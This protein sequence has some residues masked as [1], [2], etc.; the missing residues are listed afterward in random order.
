M[1]ANVRR[2]NISALFG[3]C[4]RLGRR[5]GAVA[6][7]LAL[8]AGMVP[9]VGLLP[10]AAAA[11]EDE[12]F[13]RFNAWDAAGKGTVSL[14]E[15]VSGN[16]ALLTMNGGGEAT[17]TST[18][19]AVTAGQKYRAGVSVKSD[20]AASAAALRVQ[21]FSDADGKK[22]VGE[23]TE[24]AASAPGAAFA[25][26]AGDVTVPEGARYAKLAIAFGNDKSA[27]GETYAADN[28]FLYP[29][30]R[31]API[32]DFN[33]AGLTPGQ[34]YRYPDGAN[35]AWIN[36][37]QYYVETVE[38][39]YNGAGALHYVNTD[40]IHDMHLVLIA[41]QD[42]PAGEYKVSMWVKGSVT[43]KGQDLRF[44]DA[45]NTDNTDYIITNDTNTFADWTECSYTYTSNGSRDFFLKFSRYNAVSD[46]YISHI[47]VTNT[48]TGEDVLDG[49]G[50]F[51]AAENAALVTAVNFV[52]NGDFED[53]IYTYLPLS[54]FNGSFTEAKM[55]EQPLG[56][57]VNDNADNAVSLEAAT[58]GGHG[59]VLKATRHV[60]SENWVSVGTNPIAVEG[61]T[62]Y[63]FSIDMKGTGTRRHYLLVG[64]T[65][66]RA[67]NPTYIANDLGAGMLTGAQEADLPNDWAT[68]S[69]AFTV[70]ANAVQLQIR[71]VFWG[72]VGDTMLLDNASLCPYTQAATFPDSWKYGG[73]IMPE[74]DDNAFVRLAEEGC[75]N[76]NV[77]SLHVRRSYEVYHNGG[78]DL[79]FGYLLTN[80]PAGKNYVLK[81]MVKGN[82]N[83]AGDPPNME[84]AWG[85]G[86]WTAT[87]DAVYRF[88]N[89]EYTD[90]TEV[91]FEFTSV[92][93]DWAPILFNVGGYVGTDFYIDNVRLYAAN[94]LNTNLIP[95]G[96]FFTWSEADTSRNLIPNGGFEGLRVLSVPGWSFS[97]DI[98]YAA[99]SK[100]VTFG[101]NAS[102]TS[103]RYNVEGGAIYRVKVD[104]NGG[105]LQLSFDK[106]AAYT[107]TDANG[108]FIVP[109]GAKYM[110]ASYVSESGAT[111]K[112][113]TFSELEHPENFDFELKDPAS[114]MPLNWQ[115]Y[116]LETEDDTYTRRYQAGVGVDNSAALQVT[117]QED[118]EKGALV[119]YSSR[120]EVKPN[121]VYRVTFQGKYSGE[122]IGVFPLARTFKTNGADT[123]EGTPYNWLTAANSA[124]NDGAWHSYSAD[125][126]TGS[127]AATME[128]R[129][130]VHSYKAGAE[131]L[132][133][134]VSVR[135]LGD[136]DDAN[137]GFETGEN[138]EAPFN[139]T[140]YE[141]REKPDAPGEYEEGSFGAYSVKKVDGAAADGVG[142]AAVVQKPET[143]MV[144]LYLQSA[145]IPVEG[146]TNYLLSYDAMVR[147]NKKGSVIVC[148]R[149]FTDKLGNGTD[150][151]SVNFTWVP[152]ANAYGSFDWRNC[153]ATFKTAPGTKY[154][155]I[156][157]VPNTAE[158]CEMV[159]DNV[160]VTPTEEITDPNLDFE[161][162][163]GGKPLNW[164]YATSDG[165]ADIT[166]DSSVY[167]RGGHSLHIR[168]Q[169]NRINYTT[170]EMTRRIDV[171]AGDRIE[172]VV[173]VRSKDAVSGVFA[174]VVRGYGA[175]GTVV[176]D[177]H[178]QERTLNSS[179]YLSDWQEYRITYTVTKNVKSV[180]LMLRVGGKE[181]DVYFD[182]V[183][184]YNYTESEDV[185]YAEDFSSA[186]SD[187][188]PGGWK[189]TDTQ[190]AP[191]VTVENG[192]TLSGT[193]AD[194]AALYTDIEI[195][196][197]Q[198]G[199]AF[200]AHYQTSD[201]AKG[202]LVLEGYDWRDR[203]VG[204]VVLRELTASP[205][206]TE[207]SVDFTAID[208]VYYRLRL[209]KADGDGSVML[210]N[211]QLRQ[212]SE[213]A[214][215]QGWEGSWIVHPQDYDTIESQLNNERYYFF[216][217][218]LN[219]ED[220]IKSAQLQITADDRVDVYVNGE[221]VYTETRTGDTWS[222]P[223]TLDIS[224]YLQKGRNVLA[225]RLYN[226]VYRYGLLYDGIVKMENGSALRFYSDNSAFVAR[227]SIGEDA[228]PN[229]LWTEADEQHFME[230]D[231]D[232]TTG[233]WTHAEIYAKAGGGGWGSIDFDNA[234]YSDYKLETNVFIFPKNTVYAGD[235]VEITATLKINEKLPKTNSFAVYFWKRNSTSRICTGTIALADGATTDS[236]PVGKEFEAK[237]VLTVPLFLAEG[238]YTLQFDNTVAIV[239]DYFINN[240]VGNLKVAQ[241]EKTVDTKSEV[242]MYNGKPTVFVNGIAKA[243]LWY[244]RPE[245]DTQF[246]TAEMAGLANGGIDTTIAFILPR[247]TLGELWMSDGSIKTETID[248]QMLGTLAADPN[249]QLMVAIDTTPPQWWLDQHPDECVKLSSGVISKES[250]SS[251][252]YRKEVG[253][254]LTRIIA[255]LMEQPYANNIVGF[256]ITGG[257]TYEWQ[258][259][260]MNGNANVIGDYSSVGITAF[261]K[262]LREKYTSV[263]ALRQAWGDSSVTFETAGVPDKAARTAT[264]FGS[265]LSATENRHAIDYE[266]FMGDMK[267]D[268]MLYFAEVAKKAVGG[269]LMVGTYA[270]YL[271][272]VINYDMA[273]STSQTSFQRILDSEYIDFIT[274]PWLYSEREIGYS[275]DYMSAVDSVTA[276]G[277]LYIAED[278]DRNHTT[279]MFEAPDA[280][281]AV[282]W[283]RT[284]E[285]T[286]ETLKRNYAYALSKGCG[287]YLYSLAG[288]Y[289]TDAQV[290]QL[291]SQMMQEMT[292][293]LG[294]ARESVSDVAVFY[295]EQSA[296]YMGYSGA[297]LTNELLYKALLMYQRR[298]LYSMGVPYDTYVLDDLAKGLVPEHKVNIMLS[299]TQITDTER[300]AIEE[301]LCKNGNVIIWI[302]TAGLSDGN[303][304]DIANLSALTGMQMELVSSRNGQRKSIGTV[305]VTDYDHWLTA[306]LAD[307]SFGAIEYNTLAPV[308]AVNDPTA[309]T[310]GY[311][312]EQSGWANAAG[313]AVKEMN[314]NGRQWVSIY[315]AVPC[316][317]QALLRNIL[318]HVGCHVYDENASDVV[319]ADNS[320]VS[321]HSLF[322]GEKTIRLP[323]RS[324]VYDVFNGKI[325]AEDVTEFTVNCEKSETRL[326]RLSS[327][328]K[329]RSYFT[330]TAGGS[331]TP[332]GLQT[333]EKGGSIT[334]KLQADTGY[335]LDHLMVDGVK[336]TV[337]G[338]TYTLS[339]IGESHTVIAYFAR[340]YAKPPI[341]EPDDP[342][343]DEPDT[344]TTPDTPVTPTAPD[345]NT[346]TA[347]DEPDTP[348]TPE[349]PTDEPTTPN[350]PEKKP[351]TTNTV[352]YTEHTELNWPAIIALGGGVLAGLLALLVLLLLLTRNVVFYRGGKR[353][354][355]AHA[356][357]S[358]VRVD[359]LERRGG[360]AGVTAVVKKGY[361]RRHAGQTLQFTVGGEPKASVTLSGDGEARVNL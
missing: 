208:A 224:E 315:S 110:R 149:Q 124:N 117:T 54:A 176:Q 317:P 295:D 261:R 225:I 333:V 102:A 232:M 217:Q 249:S 96:D 240:K 322:G 226:G 203:S 118:N 125:F 10:L 108:F 84:L 355:S 255:Y 227:A 228:A 265:V 111:L 215:S 319:Y 9:L 73:L 243:P 75:S 166:A 101:A 51:L 258:W 121:A 186:A 337:S 233:G 140:F 321:V 16:G 316:F 269:R 138:G 167:Y 122:S 189:M 306:G 180:A 3:R 139:W 257:T 67:G 119:I 87:G 74:N 314:E 69:T 307:V 94:D 327:D 58:D 162:V 45:T 105:K 163:A 310:L 20:A 357:R 136:A 212:T 345:D 277:K 197:P 53:A 12:R 339:D 244:S 283:T 273:S 193:A 145:M 245:R 81:M 88:A 91:S 13:E 77:G 76:T 288:T 267:T 290:Q 236:W 223:V 164:T 205:V 151:E 56:W 4:P 123:S 190:G 82:F 210:K 103:L 106:G 356:K 1:K 141:R 312:S 281:A 275:G 318:T 174:A 85:K 40:A 248:R 284:A 52:K 335:R 304:S 44:V 204:T 271:L 181:A 237:F 266:L 42:V 95:D 256:K 344:P 30:G 154:I 99:D 329:L 242:K 194:K 47:T 24:I 214:E 289:F 14:T 152:E 36:T 128:M 338:N 147:G 234:E 347:P 272:N 182:D 8:L 303:T 50:D 79:Q 251:E 211:V 336:T 150:D 348:A 104:G 293:S 93:N 246:D 183:E 185:V 334:V 65:F 278:D 351:V 131:F 353:V 159:F 78:Y 62:R 292:L 309:R 360:L 27:A 294:L 220:T 107:Q 253:E 35:S 219:L 231:Y 331:I 155:R 179:S 66:D 49:C 285:Q 90:W 31:T 313:L 276:H 32:Y 230:P 311:H 308:I 177:W 254:V 172:F 171:Q 241:P 342:T 156:W 198:Y 247:E 113:I 134:N 279:D 25:E 184:Y 229:P 142:A 352:K 98:D 297:D 127:D 72:A 263:E 187:R 126:T 89:H 221:Q 291:A 350:E 206:L 60:N 161:Y 300:K 64:Y 144:Q 2:F 170:A 39:G 259:W 196:K 129:F 92:I 358:G 137:L 68:V 28:A 298:E 19:T 325:I 262:W 48:A 359:S 6:L 200:T 55:T 195:L 346:P 158:A 169:Y 168:K 264:T 132:F 222:L 5:L 37:P 43:W 280:R 202:R 153:G 286:V 270:G 354:K 268:A 135:Y 114:D 160:A 146:N 343:P 302:F 299:A 216:R 130:E 191:T 112:S 7:C 213:P 282:G 349:T 21:F 305:E 260:G 71:I 239:S 18:L 86:T 252:L 201:N 341:V 17:L 178:G 59:G 11:A 100:T 301:R 165:I 324:T 173:H 33:A 61:G 209:E 287:L 326:F 22:T 330:R 274:C 207:I 38:N 332:E 116:V 235:T 340:V 57:Q 29:Y 361:V 148:V 15:G 120:V 192:V 46:L 250:F 328:N 238:S 115:S 218:E 34:W 157:L 296:A 63:R 23:E 97:G 320:Y 41:P 70:P 143:G 188:L 133:D 83:N 109:D 175:N 199:Y 80:A 323:K 26:L